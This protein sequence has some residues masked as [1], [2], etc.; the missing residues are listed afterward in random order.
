MKVIINGL[1][2]SAEV[3][4]LR[5]GHVVHR[6]RFSGKTRK[7]FA[8]VIRTAEKFDEHRCRFVTVMPDDWTFS[9]EVV[10]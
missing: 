3:E 7:P 10:A 5:E 2:G 9:Y 6:E 4:F 1:L 8:R